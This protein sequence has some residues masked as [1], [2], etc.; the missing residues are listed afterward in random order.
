MAQRIR[1]IWKTAPLA[2]GACL[3]LLG[4]AA[5]SD[6]DDD[7]G[8]PA[9]DAVFTGGPDGG[10]FQEFA[11]GLAELVTG[12]PG[13][14]DSVDPS[15][16]STQNLARVNAGDADY[17]LSFAGDVFLGREGRLES[18][19]TV[20]DNVAPIAA[21]YGGTIHLVVH[22]DSDIESVDDLA[23]KRI[24]PGADGSGAAH[25]AQRYFGHLGL[26]DELD[27]EHIG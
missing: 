2:L 20:Y 21:I 5:C 17:G 12:D 22:A 10:A 4:I 18:D 6:D 13:I 1:L 24:A 25:A 11:V 15:D 27:V 26:W 8:T 19:E 16:G 23:G 7:T 3:M 14:G 9:G